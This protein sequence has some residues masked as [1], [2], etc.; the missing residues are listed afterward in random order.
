M[1]RTKLIYWTSTALL[2]AM[3]LMSAYGYFTNEEVKAG[4]DH[5]GF[6][7]YFRVELGT[8]KLLGAL[9]LLIPAVPKAL[10]IFAYSGFA[11]TF[12]S[13]FVAHLASG[14]PVGAAVFPL[15]MLGI[16]ALSFSYWRRTPLEV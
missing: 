3:M 4:F 10:K 2:G 14:D 13:A 1:K 15:V 5:L 8:A 12:V 9:A 16:L 7:D 11:L 6:P